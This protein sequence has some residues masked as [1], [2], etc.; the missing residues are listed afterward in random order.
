MS[1]RLRNGGAGPF[2]YT[3]Y[4]P[5]DPGKQNYAFAVLENF[6]SIIIHWSTNTNAFHCS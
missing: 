3:G 1:V 4:G 5:W 2:H 6:I